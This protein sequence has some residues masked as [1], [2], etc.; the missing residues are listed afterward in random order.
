MAGWTERLV[1]SSV[2]AAAG[3]VMNAAITTANP[4]Q[5]EASLTNV[6]FNG[7]DRAMSSGDH[8]HYTIRNRIPYTSRGQKPI[9]II[10][11][12]RDYLGLCFFY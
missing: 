6:V 3:T 4:R 1:Q 5:I 2:A 11:H 10:S 7:N 9:K 12:V 8:N